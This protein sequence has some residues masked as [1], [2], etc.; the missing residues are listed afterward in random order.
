MKYASLSTVSNIVPRSFAVGRKFAFKIFFNKFFCLVKL[1]MSYY[2]HDAALCAI[3]VAN[4]FNQIVPRK[5]LDVFSLSENS[6]AKRI[7]PKIPSASISKTTSELSS[8][9]IDISSSTTP[10]SLH[11]FFCQSRFKEYFTQYFKAIFASVS[12]DSV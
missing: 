2:R 1:N 11:F 9:H 8:S 5:V 7:I 4:I 10:F 6:S 12:I 3:V